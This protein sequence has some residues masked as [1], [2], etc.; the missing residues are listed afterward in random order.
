MLDKLELTRQKYPV[1]KARGEVT[2]TTPSEIV[3]LEF[4]R[5]SVHVWGLVDPRNSDWPVVYELDQTSPMKSGRHP[6]E[7][8]RDIYV[9]ETRNAVARLR[10]HLVN[11]EKRQLDS[12]RVIV[13]ETFNKSACLDLESR[14]IQLLSADGSYSVLNRSDGGTRT[15]RCA[16]L[17]ST[18]TASCSLGGSG[19]LTYKSS[20]WPS[21][22]S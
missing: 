5:E 10:Q 6:E 19:G 3:P 2:N 11:P 12:I 14:L 9:G 22:S 4:D 7:R 8:L 18:S 17:S 1:D 16:S 15:A 13:D 21:A 20:T